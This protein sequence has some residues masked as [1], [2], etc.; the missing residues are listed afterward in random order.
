MFW[1]SKKIG[2]G[3][4]RCGSGFSVR[5][6]PDPPSADINFRLD[7][8]SRRGRRLRTRGPPHNEI[9]L[10]AA[11]SRIEMEVHR[12]PRHIDFYEV[13]D[14]DAQS[15]QRMSNMHFVLRDRKFQLAG[16]LNHKGTEH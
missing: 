15:I 5:A 8:K 13:A 4:A 9:D 14:V 6:G 12:I 2:C 7:V 11:S 16:L 10:P 1:W 3:I